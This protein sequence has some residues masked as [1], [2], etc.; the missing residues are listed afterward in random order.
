MNTEYKHDR[1]ICPFC[2]NEYTEPY[3]NDDTDDY[4]YEFDD[5][6]VYHY[7]YCCE[8]GVAYRITY[9]ATNVY[10]LA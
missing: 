10:K 6:N 7:R 3:A 5:G 8:C 1:Y 9:H 2:Y 4:G